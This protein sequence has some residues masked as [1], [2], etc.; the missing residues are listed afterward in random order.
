M[1]CDLR[2]R[3]DA[4]KAEIGVL[5]HLAD[6]VG[7]S[8]EW[9]RRYEIERE[10]TFIACCGEMY[11]K[12]RGAQKWVLQ[13]DASTEFFHAVA[14][15][16]KRRGTIRSL[17]WGTEIITGDVPLR[18][19]IYS[20]YRELPGK[21]E[22]GGARISALAWLDD[23]RVSMRDNICL[24]APFTLEEMTHNLREMRCYTAPG[25]DGFPV[26]FYRRFWHFLG[27]QMLR[28]LDDFTRGLIDIKRLNYGV[29][30]LL[31][32]IVGA[33]NIRQFRPIT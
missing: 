12:Q 9:A 30:T 28:I 32:K 26:I 31:S 27:P 22:G 14:N 24:T 16:R 3:K 20:F 10:L 11:W 21:A 23:A 4:L 8:G 1:E 6:T 18:D 5:N 2:C 33:E 25:P 17:R 15:G 13:G 19:H 29:L 7:I